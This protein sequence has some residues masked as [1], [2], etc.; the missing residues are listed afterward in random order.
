MLSGGMYAMN[1]IPFY[2][3]IGLYLWSI[4]P[5]FFSSDYGGVIFDI[6]GNGEINDYYVDDLR[7]I[8][9]SISLKPY[10]EISEG[11]GTI[12]DPYIVDTN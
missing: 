5:S 6:L 2:L 8:R 3:N 11:T 4:S 1:N 9:P 7:G 12:N 10:T